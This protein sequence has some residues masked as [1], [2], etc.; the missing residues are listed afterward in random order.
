M[1]SGDALARM[2]P[3][4]GTRYDP[5]LIQVFVNAL[6]KYPPGTMMLLEDGSIAVSIGVCRSKESFDKPVVRVVRD[7]SGNVPE[8]DVIVDLSKESG[9]RLVLNSRPESLRR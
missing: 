5:T 1:T 7:A 8:G 2:I 4:S 9:V 6:G 3:H